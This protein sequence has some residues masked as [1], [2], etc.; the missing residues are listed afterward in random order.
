LQASQEAEPTKL[1]AKPAKFAEHYAQAGLF[2]RSQ[3]PS[4]QQHI[5]DAFRFELTR[6]QTA[7]IRERV[8]AQLRNVD[9]RLASG[10]AN[11]LG[12]RMPEALP[13]IV[14]IPDGEVQRSSGLSLLA[15]PG[16]GTVATRRIAIMVADGVDG[17][18]VTL[19]YAQLAGAGAL[20]RYIGR[21]LGRVE[22][23]GAV[24]PVEVTF[25]AAPSVLW[26]A[27]VLPPGP[28]AAAALAADDHVVEFVMQQWRHNKVMLVPESATSILEAAGIQVDA[29][30]LQQLADGDPEAQPRLVEIAP[31]LL[32]VPDDALM[33]SLEIFVN[34]VSMHRAHER[35]NGNAME[36]PATDLSPEASTS[37]LEEDA[38]N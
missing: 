16:D 14:P 24:L 13:L 2:F 36:P 4:E 30:A 7:A 5:I 12:I 3:A 11:G 34:G 26:D 9:E 31:G 27:A 22:A 37:D 8:V 15:R 18:A 1:R 25:E 32:I 20:P 21:R 6:V 33:D 29:S 23:G 10:V 28:V 38:V 35:F 19:L 17:D